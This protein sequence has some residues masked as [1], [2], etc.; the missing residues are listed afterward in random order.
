MVELRLENRVRLP[1][2][3]I[4]IYDIPSMILFDTGASITVIDIDLANVLEMKGVLHKSE[5]TKKI[6][7]VDGTSLEKTL[8]I[9]DELCIAGITIHNM[10]VAV[11]DLSVKGL[12]VILSGYMLNKNPF[13]IS[14]AE[15]KFLISKT[16][17]DIY[18]KAYTDESRV[19]KLVVFTATDELEASQ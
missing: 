8:Y 17:S 13:A 18:T 4:D 7:G 1:V 2:F 3:S 5:L 15:R 9:L 14:M 16:H 19:T 12:N 10:P 11:Y 6:V